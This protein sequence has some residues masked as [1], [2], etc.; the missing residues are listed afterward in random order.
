[1]LGSRFNVASLRKC[2]MRKRKLREGLFVLALQS[3]PSNVRRMERNWDMRD[4]IGAVARHMNL[5]VSELAR[6]SGV[7]PSTL[8]RYVNDASRKTSITERTLQAVEG[9]TGVSRHRLPGQALP[10]GMAEADAVP[11]QADDTALKPWCHAAIEKAR[12]G[13][14][15]LDP[16][17]MRGRSLDL[18]G[19]L[20][21]DVLLVDLNRRPVSGDIVCAQIV[22]F[23]TGVAETVFRLFQ[24]PFLITHSAKMGPMRPDVVDENRVSIRGVVEGVVR[25]F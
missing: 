22:D 5:T 20:P 18:S 11:Y 19:I 12:E 14:N 17:V 25:P 13:R 21:G 6:H 8:T 3:L 23:T 4:W 9:F 7:A 24:P 1:M 10:A 15:G 2:D 16:W